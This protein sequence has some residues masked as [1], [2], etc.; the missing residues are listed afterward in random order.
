MQY[1]KIKIT[2][3][4]I[5]KSQLIEANCRSISFSIQAGSATIDNEPLIV[6]QVIS[7]NGYPGDLNKTIYKAVITAGTVLFVKREIEIE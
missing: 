1:N 3:E 5:T 2:R 6:N 4:Q 7:D